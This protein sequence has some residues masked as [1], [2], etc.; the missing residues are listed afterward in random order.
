MIVHCPHKQQLDIFP[1]FDLVVLT[2]KEQESFEESYEATEADNAAV[3]GA[4]MGV[5]VG[6]VGG[7]LVA[8]D[9]AS[10]ATYIAYMKYN[11]NLTDANPFLK[12]SITETTPDL[13]EI[14][15]EHGIANMLPAVMFNAPPLYSQGLTPTSSESFAGKFSDHFKPKQHRKPDADAKPAQPQGAKMKGAMGMFR[16]A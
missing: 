13:R 7:L 16:M 2:A 14:R 12:A 10:M 15:A 6:L 8:M 1:R 9:I 5:V 3:F 11:L 4:I